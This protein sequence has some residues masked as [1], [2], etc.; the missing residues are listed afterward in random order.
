MTSTTTHTAPAGRVEAQL[1]LIIDGKVVVND[2]MTIKKGCYSV[3]ITMTPKDCCK[4]PEE[5]PAILASAGVEPADLP[6][7]EKAVSGLTRGDAVAFA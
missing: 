1:M 2:T 4:A 7:A 5:A 6:D 3:D